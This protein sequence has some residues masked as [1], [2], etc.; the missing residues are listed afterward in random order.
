MHVYFYSRETVLMLSEDIT[1]D[2]TIL[3][4]LG[5]CLLTAWVVTFIVVMGGKKWLGWVSILLLVSVHY[6][7]Q[8]LPRVYI[9]LSRG[10]F[11]L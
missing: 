6:I 3:W 1:E 2:G 7:K 11:W 8:N 9:R 5:I 10:V 4:Y